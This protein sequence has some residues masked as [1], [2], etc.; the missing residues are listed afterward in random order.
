MEKVE[1]IEKIELRD[2][3]RLWAV[4]TKRRLEFNTHAEGRVF[5]LA[6]RPSVECLIDTNVGL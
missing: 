5:L 1:K 2:G 4:T 6:L 3:Q